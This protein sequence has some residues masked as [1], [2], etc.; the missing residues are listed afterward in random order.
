L[1]IVQGV[2]G[3]AHMMATCDWMPLVL[4]PFISGLFWPLLLYIFINY[5]ILT[6]FGDAQEGVDRSVFTEI[7]TLPIM[8]YA[9][10]GLRTSGRVNTEHN[11]NVAK[12]I[13]E[14]RPYL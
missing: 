6:G 12:K 7:F 9:L 10:V 13:I 8:F 2:V 4:R 14:V 3:M 5:K 11:K 1:Q